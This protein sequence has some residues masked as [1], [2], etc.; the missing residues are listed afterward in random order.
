MCVQ[1]E[2][3]YILTSWQR[4]DHPLGYRFIS[5]Q[6][7]W[8]L[9]SKQKKTLLF[10]PATMLWYI[11]TYLYLFQ[12]T[13][14]ET[15]FEGMQMTSLL[16]NHWISSEASWSIILGLHLNNSL[17]SHICGGRFPFRDSGANLTL[18][19]RTWTRL[20]NAQDPFLNLHHNQPHIWVNQFVV[21]GSCEL[22]C[23]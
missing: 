16:H 23:G 12:S 17:D 15:L 2:I 9:K 11:A 20:K 6:P 5:V 19:N 14:Q 10:Q 4:Q 13:Q 22:G 21:H 7:P 18:K 8:M 3:Y 1:A